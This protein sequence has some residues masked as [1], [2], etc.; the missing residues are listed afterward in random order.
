MPKARAHFL[1]FDVLA[2]EVEFCHVPSL[3][4][5]RRLHDQILVLKA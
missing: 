1:G 4:N 5:S 3:R 2:E